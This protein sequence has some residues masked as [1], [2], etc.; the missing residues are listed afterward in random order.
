MTTRSRRN[1]G[2]DM[3]VFVG[4]SIGF[5]KMASNVDCSCKIGQS[6]LAM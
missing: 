2:V 4:Y 1:E 5:T 3:V 6:K